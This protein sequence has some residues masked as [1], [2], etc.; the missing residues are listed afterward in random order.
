VLNPELVHDG[1]TDLLVPRPG[2]GEQWDPETIHT[3]FFECAVPEA[4]I[5]IFTYIRYL[6]V[7]GM[8]Q[9]GVLI[10]QGLDN[11]VLT[12]LAYS[13]YRLAM[14]WPTVEGTSF[15]TAQ[16]LRI[17][18]VEPGRVARITFRSPDG[19]TSIDVTATA[20]TPLAVR[21]HVLP[22][23]GV[24]LAETSGGS[25]QFLHYAGELVLHGVRHEVDC[26]WIRD[27][28]WRQVRRETRESSLHPPLCWTPVWFDEDFAFNAMG[29]EAP[30]TAPWR[31][32]FDIPAD[33]PTH[34]FAWVARK[35]EVRGVR[36]VHRRDLERHPIYLHPLRTELEIED[37]Q[38]EVSRVT[39]EAIAFAP[40]PQW[41]NV[42]THES[43]MRWTDDRG[44]VGFGPAQTIWNWKAQAAM[45][46]LRSHP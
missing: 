26:H 36:R 1:S 44:K 9:G 17:E 15:T 10:Y 28:S 30:D 14:P 12:D 37:D 11:L 41:Y 3:H 34:V 8:C 21:G 32:A 39:G 27:R 45:R 35:G 24:N 40:L 46:S 42:S 18:F 25:E 13:D 43:L 20:V 31:D 33:R 7:Y 2:P 22:D 6:P 19:G 23:E 5:S 38:G 4:G 29:F 16:G